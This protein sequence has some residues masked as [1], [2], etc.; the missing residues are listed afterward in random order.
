LAFADGPVN[1]FSPL[2]TRWDYLHDLPLVSTAGLHAFLAGFVDHA[3]AFS[4]HVRAHPPGMLVLLWGMDRLGLGGPRWE[5]AV[6]VAVAASMVPAAL[7]ALRAVAGETRARAAAPFLAFGPA[8]LWLATSGDALFAGVTAWAVTL[9]VLAACSEGR[10]SDVLAAGGGLLFGVAAL[11]SYGSVLVAAVAIAVCTAR[12]RYRP[13][14]LA[15]AAAALAGLAFAPAGF[16]WFEGIRSAH[17]QYLAGASRYRPQSYF[18]LGNLGAFAIA[19]GPAAVA[20][21]VALRHRPTWLLV[22]G[23]LAGVLIADLSGLS[24]GEVERIWLPFVPWIVVATSALNTRPRAAG[25][26]GLQVVTAVGVQLLV[27]SP[28]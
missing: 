6:V 23:G 2:T 5:A 13:V 24:K 4:T 22:A 12:R 9:V 3:S 21:M 25:W 27:R 19:L 16:N 11:L 1:L 14:A 7:I 10:R 8:A 17:A 26:L 18:V 20:G 28:W 15:A